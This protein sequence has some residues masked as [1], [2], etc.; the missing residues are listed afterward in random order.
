MSPRV[1]S[2]LA[3]YVKSG[4]VSNPSISLTGH[5][6]A[7]HNIYL[8]V[9]FDGSLLASQNVAQLE[10]SAPSQSMKE[11]RMDISLFVAS[12]ACWALAEE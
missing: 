7:E 5:W 9:F 2:G 3:F 12:Q 11:C 6:Q 1:W 8:V 4:T 10:R